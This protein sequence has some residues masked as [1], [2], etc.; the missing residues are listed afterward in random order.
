M[1]EPPSPVRAT[2]PVTLADAIPLDALAQAVASERREL[3][4][5]SG[6]FS[7]AIALLVALVLLEPTEPYPRAGMVVLPGGLAMLGLCSGLS[8]LLAR[9]LRRY[10]E[11]TIRE[12]LGLWASSTSPVLLPQGSNMS[13]RYSARRLATPRGGTHRT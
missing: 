7:A 10:L 3:A 11:T 2:R 5:S 6:C 13:V 1:P 8:Y 4:A 9:R 12:R